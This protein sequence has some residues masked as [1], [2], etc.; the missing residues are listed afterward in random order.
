MKVC[1]CYLNN[2]YQFY[3]NEGLNYFTLAELYRVMNKLPQYRSFAYTVSNLDELNAIFQYYPS[4]EDVVKIMNGETVTPVA[5]DLNDSNLDYAWL[6]YYTKEEVIAFIEAGYFPEIPEKT[7]VFTINPTPSTATVTI[8]GVQ[9]NS[10]VVYEGEQVVWSVGEESYKTQMGVQNVTED[11]TIDVSLVETPSED[12]PSLPIYTV[13][14]QPVPSDSYVFLDGV[15]QSCISLAEGKSVRYTVQRSGYISKTGTII[16]DGNKTIAIVLE[17]QPVVE[18]NYYTLTINPVPSTATVV[19]DGVEQSTITVEEGTTVSYEVYADGYYPQSGSLAM[20]EDNTL[21]VVLEENPY[22][23]PTHILTINPVPST[24]TVTING[25]VRRIFEGTE[26]TVANWSVKADGYVTQSGSY[27]IGTANYEMSVTLEEYVPQN[28]TFTINPVPAD[29]IVTINGV[30]QTSITVQEGTVVTYTVEKEGYHTRSESLVINKNTTLNIELRQIGYYTFTITTNP[31]YAIVTI[32]GEITNSVTVPSDT[33]VTWT[34]TLTGYGTEAGT[35]KVTEDSEMHVYLLCLGEPQTVSTLDEYENAGADTGVIDLCSYDLIPYTGV[36]DDGGSYSYL[37]SNLTY[38]EGDLT[39]NGRIDLSDAFLGLNDLATVKLVGPMGGVASM[40][41]MFSG[42]DS[43]TE[44]DID[45]FDIQITDANIDL[46]YMFEN[47]TN[48]VEVKLT[49]KLKFSNVRGAVGMFYNCTNL[50]KVTINTTYGDNTVY[51]NSGP[52]FKGQNMFENCTSLTEV[53]FTGLFGYGSNNFKDM[54]KNVNTTGTLYYPCKFKWYYSSIIAEIPSTW[55]AVAEGDCCDVDEP[56]IITSET[57]LYNAGAETGIIDMCHYALQF[58]LGWW[59]YTINPSVYYFEADLGSFF[60]NHIASPFCNSNVN[61]VVYLGNYIDNTPDGLF[62]GCKYLT[63]ISCFKETGGYGAGGDNFFNGCESLKD[64][65]PLKRL[66]IGDSTFYG[67]TSLDDLSQ[68]KR[69]IM[70]ND[71]SRAFQ[72]C[73]S[74]TSL[75]GIGQ[76]L[77]GNDNG[78]FTSTFNGCTSLTDISALSDWVTNNVVYMSYMFYDCNALT[79][80]TPLSNWNTDNVVGASYMFGNCTSLT[81]LTGLN[82]AF[83]NATDMSGMFYGCTSLTDV[84]DM[85]IVDVYS[86]STKM[87]Q[88][89]AYCTSLETLTGLENWYAGGG[90]IGMFEGCSSLSDISALS[91]WGAPYNASY[92]FKDCVSLTDASCLSGC[93]WFNTRNADYMFEGCTNLE[94]VGLF[95][96]YFTSAS[97]NYMFKDCTSL[98]DIS[99]LDPTFKDNPSITGMFLNCSSLTDISPLNSWGFSTDVDEINMQSLFEGCTS[100]TTADLS[101]GFSPAK[102]DMRNMFKNCTSLTEV[103]FKGRCDTSK[104]YCDGM[105]D[106]VETTGTFYYPADYAN[107]YTAVINAI[108]STW[109]AVAY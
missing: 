57:E 35:F 73:T 70:R 53:R 67:C 60:N 105:F 24:A 6:N 100:L 48:L 44:V 75:N 90:R 77:G 27:T 101:K 38:F 11:T 52:V 21:E 107:T 82:H 45:S 20:N 8:N 54:F 2:K 49:D 58:D 64:L 91:G 10:V 93:R 92:M 46:S 63:D 66:I 41:S 7:Y 31:A 78:R 56:I 86:S 83:Y 85:N 18:P 76:Y 9:R 42:C 37:T 43:L 25:M 62:N 102:C 97:M 14:I 16:A 29:A 50:K 74:L 71:I 13:C 68:V 23:N 89:F 95:D 80:L 19:I 3:A 47:C 72:G 104:S 98:T 61:K 96:S 12:E 40:K 87:D 65:T 79:D 109:T 28:Y 39:T 4:K 30:E 108:P 51:L 103:R 5:Q 88:M 17:E 59:G 55:T 34:A 1:N 22:Y 99:G 15:N 32:N 26:G 69:V 36:L 33:V 84:S 94:K 106:G 81:S